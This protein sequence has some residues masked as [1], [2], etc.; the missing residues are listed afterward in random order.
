MSDQ[1]AP[2][3]GPLKI[4]GGLTIGATP[5]LHQAFAEYAG[6][7]P[8]IVLDL[9]GVHAC[10]TAGLQLICSLRCT[11]AQARR[12]FHIAAL[13]PEIEE[14]AAALGLRM[15]EPRPAELTAGAESRST[16]GG[17]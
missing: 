3:K 11:A 13:S 8:D 1:E 6:R 7:S 2:A 17:I 9:S 15:E 12:R 10:D 5:E 16:D 4:A 14:A